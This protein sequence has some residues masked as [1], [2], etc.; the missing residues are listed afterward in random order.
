MADP[1]PEPFDAGKAAGNL[2]LVEM[3][4]ELTPRQRLLVAGLCT[5]EW[6]EPGELLIAEGAA[7]DDLYILLR[8]EVN[9]ST[10][11][12]LAPLEQPER[13][14]RMLRKMTAEG[15]PVLGE[16][17]LVGHALRNATVRCATRCALYRVDSAGLR[18]KMDADPEIGVVIYRHLCQI[19]YQ[20]MQASNQDILKLSTALLFALED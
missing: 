13:H 16:T 19:L 4:R 20:R 17:A 10:R 5:L 15:T 6:H 18:A 9:V 11:L 14:E 3:F 8:G 12:K 2:A 7:A 1:T